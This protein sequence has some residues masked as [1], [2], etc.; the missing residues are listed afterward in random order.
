M[1]VVGDHD[2]H[3]LAQGFPHPPYNLRVAVGVAFHYHGAVKG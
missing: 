3:F 2:W 1:E